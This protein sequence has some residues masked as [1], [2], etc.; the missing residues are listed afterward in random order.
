MLFLWL[1]L[2]GWMNGIVCPLHT[3]A[4]PPSTSRSARRGLL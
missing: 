4:E 3:R 2:A 1:D